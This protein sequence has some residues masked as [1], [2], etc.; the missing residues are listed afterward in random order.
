MISKEESQLRKISFSEKW[1]TAAREDYDFAIIP[2]REKYRDG[3]SAVLIIQQ[4]IK[5]GNAAIG[6]GRSTY[7]CEST[8]TYRDDSFMTQVDLGISLTSFVKIVFTY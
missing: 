1:Q 6:N 7:S 2:R 5:A 8:V 4:C 3:T